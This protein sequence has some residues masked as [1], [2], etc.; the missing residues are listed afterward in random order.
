MVADHARHARVSSRSTTYPPAV[1]D[2]HDAIVEAIAHG[3]GAG[4]AVRLERHLV[5]SRD[6]I[7]EHLR[8]SYSA[9]A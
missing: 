8:D 2:D 1:W 6:A 4:A 3:D 5:S 9:P 7:L